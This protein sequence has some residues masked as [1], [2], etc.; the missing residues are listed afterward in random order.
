[1]DVEDAR[2]KDV[3]PEVACLCLSQS[4]THSVSL[5]HTHPFAISLWM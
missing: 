2:R 4:L 5:L 3:N 1:M